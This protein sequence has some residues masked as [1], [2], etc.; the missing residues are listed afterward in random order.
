MTTMYATPAAANY[1]TSPTHPVPKQRGYRVCDHCGAIEQPDIRFRL[2][3]GC[4][5]VSMST[6]ICFPILIHNSPYHQM[7]TQYCVRPFPLKS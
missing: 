5:S 1:Y 7:T 2:C 4:V 6:S 3:G